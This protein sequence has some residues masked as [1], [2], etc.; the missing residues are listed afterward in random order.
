MGA[1]K[2]QSKLTATEWQ[3]LI[4]AMEAIHRIGVPA[5]TYMD[6]VKVH[7]RAMTPSDHEG[8]SWHVH[9]MNGMDGYNFVSWHRYFL[10][11][12]ER[13]LQQV[14]P[15]ITIPYWDATNDRA[16]PAALNDP[17]LLSRWGVTR[18]IWN[19]GQLAT[20]QEEAHILQVPTF[21]LFQRTLEGHIHGGVHNAVGG[22][23]AGSASPSDP[24]FFLHHAN[25]DRLWATWQ[26]EHHG[27]GPSNMTDPL[28]PPP[29]FDVTVAQVQDITALAYSYEI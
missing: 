22:D 8:M 15:S 27:L 3:T 13:R 23:M 19:P 25:I 1:R 29:L 20:P 16:I 24:L 26:T 12:M 21:R 18:G 17:A 4:T 7:V 14:N 10:I 11:R 2:N 5:P 9:S 28:K 6:F